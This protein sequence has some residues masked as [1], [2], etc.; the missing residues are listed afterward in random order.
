[1]MPS[2]TGILAMTVSGAVA[3]TAW[4]LR[5]KR[6]WATIGFSVLTLVLTYAISVNVIAKPDGIAISGVFIAGIILISVISR[7]SRTT[8]LRVDR[9]DFDLRARRFITES[10]RRDGAMNLIANQRQAG[11]VAE[12]AEKEAMCCTC[13][14]S[15][16]AAIASCG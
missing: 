13:E 10:F 11:D 15:K 4:S 3:V 5:H 14:G 1:M 9:I 6:R 7:V 2:P 8:E 16:S 12:C